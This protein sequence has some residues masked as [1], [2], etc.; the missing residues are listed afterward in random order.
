MSFKAKDLTYDAKE[1]TFLRR[2]RGE[3]TGDDSARHERPI[4]RNKRLKQ[5]DEE[6]APTYVLEESNQSLTKAEYEALI[7]GKSEPETGTTETDAQTGSNVTNVEAK[8]AA[9][10]PNKDNIAEVGKT[11]KKR[12]AVKVIG[13]PE[14]EEKRDTTKSD[15]KPTKKAKKKTKPVKLSFGD[16]GES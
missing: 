16:Q 8:D 1:P 10:K 13:E 7:A 3:V 12:K 2:L 11:S 15:N 5:D 4:P 9:I 14:D 6:D